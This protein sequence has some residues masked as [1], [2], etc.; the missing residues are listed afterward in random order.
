M[1]T[2]SEIH[3]YMLEQ[4]QS[5]LY[6]PSMYGGEFP[7]F[8]SMGH[9]AFV[10]ERER[11]W[12]TLRGELFRNGSANDRGVEGAFA[13]LLGFH[14]PHA[15]SEAAAS[16]YARIAWVMGWLTEPR[17]E[18]LKR[19]LTIDEY[20]QILADVQVRTNLEADDPDTIIARCG[21]PSIRWGTS[22]QYPCILLYLCGDDPRKYIYFDFWNEWY[23]D[24]SG[25]QV[26]GKYGP[27]PLLRN[28]RRPAKS[29]AEEFIWTPFGENLRESRK[30]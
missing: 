14:Q 7:I 18:Y 12:E 8:Q 22:Q 25:V 11:E 24:D 23:K 4:V 28:I 30:H 27:K 21:E 17:A 13:E 20:E 16:V 1:K 9:L 6:R 19:L 15:H 26:P 5:S 29:F 10:E 3:R 2:A